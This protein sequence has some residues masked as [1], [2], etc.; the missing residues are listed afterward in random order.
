MTSAF[1]SQV[2]RYLIE[3]AIGEGGMSL[4]VRARDPKLS[5]P[6]AIKLIRKS[7]VAQDKMTELCRLLHREARTL[8]KFSHP[9]V[10]QIYDYSGADSE[11]PF[12]VYELLDGVTLEQ[13][14]QGFG[15]LAPST[16]ASIGY[17]ILTALAAAHEQ[18]L[19]HR[20][21]KPTNI[22]LG[23]DGR[24]VLIDFGLARVFDS[25]ASDVTLTGNQTA[26]YGSPCFMAPELFDGAEATPAS[27]IFAWG[28]A[29][30]EM[31]TGLPAF[32][33]EN[34]AE[35]I[36]AVQGMKI[37][38]PVEL[39]KLQ[40]PLGGAVQ[41]CLSLDPK[42]RP[43]A[44]ILRKQLAAFLETQEVSDPRK[45]VRALA[46]HRNAQA[47]SDEDGGTSLYDPAQIDTIRVPKPQS[48]WSTLGS[49]GPFVFAMAAM[50]LMV[51]AGSY[52]LDKL[53]ELPAEVSITQVPLSVG[54][55]APKDTPKEVFALFKFNGEAEIT[56]DGELIGKWTHSIR[57]A[58]SPGPHR[59]VVKTKTQ[60]H[61]RDVLLLEDTDPIISFED[62]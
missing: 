7:A 48:V 34:V 38:Q 20:D 15:A 4:I 36:R 28:C 11:E 43:A 1:P 59:V 6:V 2:D 14:L 21:L 61:E 62:P 8:A 10:V 50:A 51:S 18:G 54:N 46:E 42:A 23:N 49:R 37:S 47:E 30:F 57:L 25:T 24:V 9:N 41:Q 16:A 40:A 29:M 56:V 27:D 53:S 5:R 12:I 33:G 52:L 45:A 22:M 3:E 39:Q 60:T 19:V 32:D 35:I 58:L 17:E 44:E 55:S 13:S 26:L 31:L